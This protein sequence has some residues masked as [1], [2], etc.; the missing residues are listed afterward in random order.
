MTQSQNPILSPEK[1]QK[2]GHFIPENWKEA[3]DGLVANPPRGFTFAVQ[4]DT[5][6]SVNN[7]EIHGNNLKALSHFVPLKFYANFGD[8]IKGY[9]LVSC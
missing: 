8:Y 3:V 2:W 5:H 9:F 7:K 1:Q 4:S 6:F